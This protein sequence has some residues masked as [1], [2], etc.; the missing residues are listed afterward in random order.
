[1]SKHKPCGMTLDQTLALHRWAQSGAVVEWDDTGTVTDTTDGVPW[2][3]GK[4]YE[5]R[6]HTS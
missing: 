1:M 5:S 3:L 4:T 2:E 6:G